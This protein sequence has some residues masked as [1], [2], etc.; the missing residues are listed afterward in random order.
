MITL[1][2]VSPKQKQ[3]LKV[4][5]FYRLLKNFLYILVIYSSVLA[6]TLIPINDCIKNI[7]EQV[8]N[9]KTE[10]E[11]RDK[12][13]TQKIDELNQRMVILQQIQTEFFNWSIYYKNLSGLVPE[14]VSLND[15]YSNLF[16]NTVVIKGYAKTRNSLI[17]FKNSLESSA[18]FT[19]IN[20]PLSNFLTEE[21]IT[22]EIKGKINPLMQM[23][24][25]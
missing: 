19:D 20:I 16:E 14:D 25:R 7:N 22:F 4:R 17:T 6:S 1:N 9:R 24:V 12:N 8:N 5:K 10:T 2:L 21:G 15:V 23:M 11:L 3:F 13:L 18:Y